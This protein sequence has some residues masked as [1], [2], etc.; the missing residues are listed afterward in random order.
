MWTD[1]LQSR[2]GT[3]FWNSHKRE[4][5]KHAIGLPYGPKWCPVFP[6]MDL[7][8]ESHM[9]GLTTRPPSP[10]SFLENYPYQLEII[11]GFEWLMEFKTGKA[12]SG[13]DNVPPLWHNIPNTV[14]ILF[15]VPMKST[16]DSYTLCQVL[17]ILFPMTFSDSCRSN[18]FITPWNS[19]A[20]EGR[21][22]ISEPY[23]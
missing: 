8:E 6:D 22:S 20:S 10:T 18:H 19:K 15:P 3:F 21:P 17:N 1:P 12:K 14:N 16:K 2:C 11:Q 9:R 13:K 5:K 7:I 4:G 23:W